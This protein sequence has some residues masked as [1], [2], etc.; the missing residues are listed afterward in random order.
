MTPAEYSR[1]SSRAGG[2]GM[3]KYSNF[4]FNITTCIHGDQKFGTSIQQNNSAT[5]LNNTTLLKD[6][7]V[8][9]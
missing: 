1:D 5:H 4:N 3:T 7:K 8:S 6:N 9:T 2:F